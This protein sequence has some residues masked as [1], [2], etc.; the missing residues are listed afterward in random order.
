MLP[1][2]EHFLVHLGNAIAASQAE[3]R[4][5]VLEGLIGLGCLKEDASTEAKET[6][7]E[8]CLQLGEPLR[9][10]EH[11]PAEYL[12]ERGEYCW[13]RSQMTRRVEKRAA[14]SAFPRHFT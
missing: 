9:E 13:S 11:Q 5:Q 1:C 10:A 6:L 12:N 7:T 2:D 3:D 14:A 4:E 8:L